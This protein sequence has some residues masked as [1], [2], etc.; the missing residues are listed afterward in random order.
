MI[1]KPKSASNDSSSLYEI[2]KWPN[3]ANVNTFQIIMTRVYVIV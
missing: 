3:S 1:V 2:A